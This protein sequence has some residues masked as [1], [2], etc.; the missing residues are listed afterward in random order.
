MSYDFILISPCAARDLETRD[1]TRRIK[2]MTWEEGWLQIRVAGGELKAG[3]PKQPCAASS[4]QLL[5]HL[6]V[7][8]EVTETS[9]THVHV[10][11]IT[12]D[13]PK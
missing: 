2:K 12:P 11:L 1:G 13:F 7:C 5:A 9:K 4:L 3:Y 10:A 8:Q 6:L